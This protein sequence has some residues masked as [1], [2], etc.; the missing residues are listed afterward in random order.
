MQV[1]ENFI[2]ELPEQCFGQTYMLQKGI[3]FF[4]TKEVRACNY[5][6]QQMN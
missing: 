4:K 2:S 3:K 6:L 5:E 1:L